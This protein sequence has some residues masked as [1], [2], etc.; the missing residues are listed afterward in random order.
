MSATRQ[1]LWLTPDDGVLTESSDAQ[2][3]VERTIA[4]L[5]LPHH[6]RPDALGSASA[7]GA[8]AAAPAAQ[9]DRLSNPWLDPAPASSAPARAPAD[10]AAAASARKPQPTPALNRAAH[11]AFLARM[12]E[13]LPGPYVAFD[14]SRSWVLYWVTH[15]YDLL[16]TVLDPQSRAQAI[17]TLLSFQNPHGGFGGGP[18]QIAHLMSTYPALCALAIVGGP[19]PAPTAADVKAGRS[20]DV[21]RG[22]WDAIDRKGMYRWIMSLKQPD[23]S[24][25]VHQGGEVDVRASY[26]VTCI[27]LLLGIC[28]PELVAG[29]KGFIISCQTYEGG[30]AASS[31]PSLSDSSFS[32][33]PQPQLGEAHGGYAHCALASYLSLIT[34]DETYQEICNSSDDGGIAAK[35]NSTGLRPSLNTRTFDLDALLRWACQQQGLAIELGAM[36]GRTNKL[37]DGC[38][39]WFGGAGLFAVLDACLVEERGKRRRTIS[40]SRPVAQ[41]NPT[42]VTQAGTSRTSEDG[43]S[44]DSEDDS[45]FTTAV[46]DDWLFDPIA[47]QEYILIAAQTSTNPIA[48]GASAGGLRDKPGKKADAY[49]TCYNLSGLSLCQHRIVR[50]KEAQVF[51]EQAWKSSPVAE[52]EPVG[53]HETP[54]ASAPADGSD[55]LAQ[56]DKNVQ[57]PDEQ[58]AAAWQKACYVSALAWLAEPAPEGAASWALGDPKTN[59]VVPT[60]PIFNLTFPRVKTMMDWAYKQR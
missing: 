57:R 52:T 26:C 13:P 16:R 54:R 31:Q 45:A 44:T 14:S 17:T 28:T 29:M 36:R 51:L 25:V 12:L 7:A 43:W 58:Q 59:T 15:S 27:S 4:Q 50:S 6:V 37:V 53:G 24:F 11:I 32:F 42:H 2:L 56:S 8:A 34:L 60:H 1:P 30:L 33:G 46:Q 47:L 23:G 35:L 20:V 18:N 3:E 38:Y 48:T 22:G 19:G 10:A 40:S 55:D 49:H 39:G 41:I 5:L 21:G 9:D